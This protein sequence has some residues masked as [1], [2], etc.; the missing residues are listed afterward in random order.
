M[1]V[2]VKK[3]GEVRFALTPEGPVK[4]V[5][6]AGSFNHWEPVQMR[7]Q[8]N[9]QYIRKMELPKG[10]HEYKFIVD[11]V[12]LH[13]TGNEACLRNPLGTLNSVVLVQ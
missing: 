1:S 6:L 5:F 2:E 9:G 8:K 11:D 10:A 3:N 7:K 12:W 4:N 13:D